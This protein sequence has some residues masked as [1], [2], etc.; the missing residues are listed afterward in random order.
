MQKWLWEGG[1]VGW[2]LGIKDNHLNMKK[3][4]TPFENEQKIQPKYK[5]Y[6][7]I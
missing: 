6:K 1:G 2:E 3:N 7:E 4:W 5:S